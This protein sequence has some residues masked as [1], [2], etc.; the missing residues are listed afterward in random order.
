MR[1][2]QDKGR[3][4]A[5]VEIGVRLYD[6]GRSPAINARVYSKLIENP[7]TPQFTEKSAEAY[8]H[9]ATVNACEVA[10][11][12][13]V[14]VA[15]VFPGKVQD[16]P[17]GIH[18]QFD[19]SPYTGLHQTDILISLITC[20]DYQFPGSSSHH[21]TAYRSFFGDLADGV[22]TRIALINADLGK[23]SVINPPNAKL[24]R[25]NTPIAN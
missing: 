12:E 9:R 20:I 13:N 24:V 5:L 10:L 11:K 14:L 4:V 16:L 3:P 21:Q 7:T 1:I 19:L 6:T 17:L 18:V 25:M 2:A 15:T 8:L 22:S 23:F